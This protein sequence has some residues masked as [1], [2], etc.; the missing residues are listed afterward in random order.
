[1]HHIASH[2]KGRGFRYGEKRMGSLARRGSS[3]HL[4]QFNSLTYL[5]MKK[6]KDAIPKN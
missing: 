3:P 5:E 4:P 2:L 6:N 1:M